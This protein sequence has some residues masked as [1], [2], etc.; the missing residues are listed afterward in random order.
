MTETP[1]PATEAPKIPGPNPEQAIVMLINNA[2]LVTLN[3][4]LYTLRMVPTDRVMVV[5]CQM[6]GRFVGEIVSTGDLAPV[7]GMRRECREA[8]EKALRDVKVR[9]M[10]ADQA[11]Q[12]TPH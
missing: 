11:K 2:L 7:L 4:L 6:F 9:P 1:T 3:G 10:P 12:P 8:F 5:A